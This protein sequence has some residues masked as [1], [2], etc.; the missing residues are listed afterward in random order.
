[1]S[2]PGKRLGLAGLT[3]VA[4]VSLTAIVSG[5]ATAGTSDGGGCRG[6]DATTNGLTGTN[7]HDVIVGTPGDDVID[8][9]GGND[10]VCGKNGNDQIDGGDGDDTIRANAGRDTVHGGTGEDN[11]HGNAGNDGPPI[12]KQGSQSCFPGGGKRGQS[13]CGL[14]GGDDDDRVGGGAGSDW[15][16]GEA[17]DD[18]D[19]GAQSF[20]N[21]PDD[22]GTNKFIACELQPSPPMQ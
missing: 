10:L 11:I 15:V 21:C 4:A 22:E 19:K 14:F 18:V 6:F 17:G 16:D 12:G 3:A 1:M 8:A 13:Q 20:D 9:K 5:G 2:F 7:H